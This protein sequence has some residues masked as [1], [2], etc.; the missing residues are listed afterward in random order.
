MKDNFT[1]HIERLQSNLRLLS[2]GLVDDSNKFAVMNDL[3][4]DIRVVFAKMAE[5]GAE[6]PPS[7]L[8]LSIFGN[9]DNDEALDYMSREVSRRPW[10]FIVAQ[11][12]GIKKL[13]PQ[14]LKGRLLGYASDVVNDGDKADDVL[15]RNLS[16]ICSL[17]K[18]TNIE[19]ST[20]ICDYIFEHSEDMLVC[21]GLCGVI[22][23]SGKGHN[24][25]A[26]QSGSTCKVPVVAV[27]YIGNDDYLYIRVPRTGNT[28]DL[29]GEYD[30]IMEINKTNKAA[31]VADKELLLDDLRKYFGF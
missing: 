10:D 27:L 6:P 31:F 8:P 23:I 15:R 22:D 29:S 1:S 2:D 16:K 25:L 4:D 17:A 21:D 26:I 7:A 14:E 3:V 12:G 11:G 24:V 19:F 28:L 18:F 30:K 5:I 20:E 13:T 9:R